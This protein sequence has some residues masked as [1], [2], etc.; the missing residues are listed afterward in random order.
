MSAAK[1]VRVTVTKTRKGYRWDQVNPNGTIGA[2]SPKLYDTKSN[3][4]RAA[5][6]Q[7]AKMTNAVVVMADDD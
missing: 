4:K 3:A 1:A 7:A 5:K 2:V 6:S